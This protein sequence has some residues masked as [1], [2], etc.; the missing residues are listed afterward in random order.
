[1]TIDEKL[2][3]AIGALAD[4]AFSDD[5]TEEVRKAKAKRIY[6]ELTADLPEYADD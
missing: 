4:I 3:L 5:M 2:E 6:Q 1:M